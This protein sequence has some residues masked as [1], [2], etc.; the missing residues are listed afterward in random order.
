MNNQIVCSSYRASCSICQWGIQENE[1]ENKWCGKWKSHSCVVRPVNRIVKHQQDFPFRCV[2]HSLPSVA[3]AAAIFCSQILQK[4]E[5]KENDL[6]TCQFHRLAVLCHHTHN[7]IHILCRSVDHSRRCRRSF[8]P[9]ERHR[10][11]FAN[12]LLMRCLSSSS[13]RSALEWLWD[14]CGDPWHSWMNYCCYCCWP[15]DQN[16]RWLRW[17]LYKCWRWCQ[18]QLRLW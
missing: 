2:P 16:R 17:R 6:I 13:L 15:L 7:N 14:Q 3:K 18:L 5:E 11:S 1:R 8:L 4:E 12:E 10:V 9:V